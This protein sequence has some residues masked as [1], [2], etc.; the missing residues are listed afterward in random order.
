MAECPRGGP[1]DAKRVARI[2]TAPLP[3][4]HFTLPS[5]LSLSVRTQ[6]FLLDSGVGETPFTNI[7]EPKTAVLLWNCLAIRKF[8]NFR[9][10]IGSL[11]ICSSLFKFWIDLNMI[12][13]LEGI[14]RKFILNINAERSRCFLY[15]TDISPYE[16][17]FLSC[18]NY[19]M[20]F[21]VIMFL[22]EQNLN[23]FWI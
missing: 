3:R 8:Y 17:A 19:F 16:M 15:N 12:K 2:D 18:E 13:L 1:R 11:R 20:I 7:S 9:Y 10:K 21:K 22:Y 5:G 4:P 14:K 23:V 6:D